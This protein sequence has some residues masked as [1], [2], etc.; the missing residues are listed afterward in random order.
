MTAMAV[1]LVGLFIRSLF[2]M[3]TSSMVI[4]RYLVVD[5]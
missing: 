1:L 2:H 5:N 3:G 4:D